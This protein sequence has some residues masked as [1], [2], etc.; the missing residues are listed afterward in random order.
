M[1]SMNC[2]NGQTYGCKKISQKKC[3]ILLVDLATQGEER[4]ND[5]ILTLG[6]NAIAMCDEIKDFGHYSQQQ[7]RIFFVY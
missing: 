3:A 5:A 1:R 6:S 2:T 4:K 7:N